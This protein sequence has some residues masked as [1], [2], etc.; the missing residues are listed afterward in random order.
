MLEKIT[1]KFK[2]FGKH[3]RLERFGVLTLLI[4]SLLSLD[5]GT[6]GYD[7]IQAMRDRTGAQVMYTTRAQTFLP[8]KKGSLEV[9][10]IYKSMDSTSVFLW[11]KVNAQDNP[12]FSWD[13]KNYMISIYGSDSKGNLTYCKSNPSCS[14]YFFQAVEHM[15]IYLKDVNG[16]P[17]QILGMLVQNVV[18]IDL[19]QHLDTYAIYFNPGGTMCGT[20]DC[21]NS[22]DMSP[23]NIYYD[24]A[25]RNEE[26]DLRNQLSGNL[27]AMYNALYNIQTYSRRVIG[28]G[29]TVPEQPELIRDDFRLAVQRN[30][31]G[32]PVYYVMPDAFTLDDQNNVLFYKPTK[33]CAGGFDFNWREGSV[34]DGYLKD[35]V[36][37]G[38][39]YRDYI[40]ETSKSDGTAFKTDDLRW[41]YTSDGA[42][43]AVT[44]TGKADGTE[45]IRADINRLIQAWTNYYEYKKYYE[46]DLLKQLLE[47]EMKCDTNSMN[48]SNYSSPDR[49]FVSKNPNGK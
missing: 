47:L 19:E 34:L 36:D 12:M 30:E 45:A 35:L 38:M 9:E 11:M 42:A 48:V 27:N 44:S 21:L 40:D 46:T 24:I 20:L 33:L 1:D 28:Y 25:I 13:P 32:E 2:I 39:S 15:G 3:Y 10:G 41:Y 43:F 8:G 7:Y 18:P 6:I 29:I 16:F 49:L 5:V 26:R 22:G 17:N 23:R 4:V 14:V 37:N 31:I